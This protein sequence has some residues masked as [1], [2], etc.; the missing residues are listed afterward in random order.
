MTYVLREEN[1][2]VSVPLHTWPLLGKDA[3]TSTLT[4]DVSVTPTE[5]RLWRS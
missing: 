2:T 3:I 5:E 4:W 1:T